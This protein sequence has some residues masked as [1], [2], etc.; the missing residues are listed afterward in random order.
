MKKIFTIVFSLAVSLAATAQ[1]A[2]EIEI[3][4]QAEAAYRIGRFD[5][6]VSLLNDN[7]SRLTSRTRS[8]AYHLLSLCYMEKDNSDEATR[9]ASLLLKENPYYTPTLSDPLRF[10]DL[11]ES[12]KRGKS[13]TITTASQQAESV[14]E[15]PVPVTLITEE[16]IKSSG[17]KT[18]GD[19]LVM[20]VPGMSVVEGYET[21]V[22]MHGV[23]SSSQEKILI[24][25]DGHR[26]NS[27]ATNSEAPDFRTNLDKI[28]QIEVL[29]GPASSLYGNVALT[30]VVNIITKSG[31]DVDGTLIRGGIGDD[32]TYKASLL[33]GKSMYE[34]DL[35]LWASVYSSEGEK[36]HVGIYDDEFYGKVERDGFM[37]L[38]GFNHKPAYDIGVK[39]KWK[40]IKFM[41]ST[42]YAKKSLPYI[43]V[44]YPSLYDYDKY[45]QING[46]K[47]GRGRET[48]RM[49][50]SYD[51]A[52]GNWSGKIS[53]FVDM[54]SCSN[55]D[56][57]GDTIVPMDRYLPVGPG[58]IM[59]GIDPNKACDYGLY[60]VQAWNDY[61]YG[62]NL[63]LAYSFKKGKTDGSLLFGAQFESY[64][65]KDNTMIVG[66]HFDRVILTYSDAN[67]SILTG[68]EQNLSWFT[69]LKMRIGQ[70]FVFNGGLRYDHK[71]RYNDKKLDVLSPRLS[72][73]YKIDEEANVK[74]SYSHSFVDAPYF[75]R[76]TTIATYSGGNKLDAEEMDG[77]QLTVSK[78][79]LKLNME[80]ELNAYYN[81]LK[82][83]VSFGAP[84]PDGDMLSNAGKL[85]V[86]GLE[87]TV[88]YH[89]DKFHANAHISYQKVADT[90]NY[91]V[92]DNHIISVADWMMNATAKYKLLSWKGNALALT[93][94][95]S[96]QGK[97]YTPIVSP[98]VF[99]GETPFSDPGKTQPARAI[100]NGG[101]EYTH[102]RLTATLNVYN[103]L[104]TDYFY[105]SSTF[106]P[107]PQQHRNTLASIS[108]KF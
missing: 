49:E 42:Q 33:L 40:D 64:T 83:I 36:R 12:M 97:Q 75:Y 94:N 48:T 37:L 9:Y 57:A 100:V 108:Y 85:S 45:R 11:I 44:F 8:T 56:I 46:A 65:M 52:W 10:V 4:Q 1:T 2:A 5:E 101:I 78:K 105:G 67:K 29:R 14:E 96:Y 26:L 107:F 38:N 20:F 31:Y 55:Y 62:G 61:T 88:S 76:A 90:D 72:F 79:L 41:F 50:L 106:I 3:C 91:T 68:D 16:M 73:I 102:N 98:L 39:V 18:L 82:N 13:A 15:T 93:A 59:E 19:L 87:G 95:V 7:M 60:Q 84:N 71:K 17:A 63:Q 43:S 99:R 77:Y 47:P 103:L 89:S 81:N 35:L 27:R 58:E 21:N 30:A 86:W 66:D 54:E 74:L 23:Y 104:N 32:N 25:L 69:Q 70:H 24:M 6:A 92:I 28:K 80:C 34:L 51:K 22:A 53:A